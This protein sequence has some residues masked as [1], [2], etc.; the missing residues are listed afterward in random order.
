MKTLYLSAIIILISMAGCKK[1]NIANESDF[2]KSYNIWLSFKSNAQNSYQY[3]TSSGSVFGYGS[4]TKISV[5]N[6]KIVSRDFIS[7]QLRRNGTSQKDTIKQW[8][9][10]ADHI[11][12]HSNDT[13]ESLTLDAV[14][15]KAKTVWLK[16][17]KKSNSIYF[18]A[19]NNGMISNCG[20]VPNGCQDDCF[21]GIT[22]GAITSM[23]F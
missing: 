8:H 10:D 20:Y 4:E 23:Q 6:G 16:A 2:N 18:E 1:D 11:N 3:T 9:E 7:T 13:D 21:N 15:Q 14:Y 5:I 12:T 17:D 19:K 22:I